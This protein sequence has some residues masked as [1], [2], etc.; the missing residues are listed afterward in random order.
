MS[1][2]PWGIEGL[3]GLN[4]DTRVQYL[5]SESDGIMDG[6]RNICGTGSESDMV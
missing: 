6:M 3:L 5:W 2:L 4:I 1:I